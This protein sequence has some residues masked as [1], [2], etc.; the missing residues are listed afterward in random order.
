[1]DKPLRNMDSSGSMGPVIDHTPF[2]GK[3]IDANFQTDEGK[4]NRITGS[5]LLVRT[6]SRN[7]IELDL[8][9]RNL[10]LSPEEYVTKGAALAKELEA[11]YGVLIADFS[12]VWGNAGPNDEPTLYTTVEEV[13]G[14][15]L[16]SQANATNDGDTLR[17]QLD[18]PLRGYRTVL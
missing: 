10:E 14:S 4:I 12:L 8:A 1:M 13:Q 15:P 11:T 16:M 9:Y 2:N 6:V 18:A 17:A 3:L 5:D 7:E